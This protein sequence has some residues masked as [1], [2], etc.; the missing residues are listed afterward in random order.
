MPKT[1][2]RVA[3]E[4][5]QRNQATMEH[6]TKVLDAEAARVLALGQ[7]MGQQELGGFYRSVIPGL[8]DRWGRVNATAAMQYY[9]AQRLEWMRRNPSGL[10]RSSRQATARAADRFAERQL[11]TLLYKASMPEF[12]AV[13]IAEPIIG[14][15]MD[16]MMKAGFGES[17]QA[18]RNALTRAVASYNR[19]TILYN[20]ALDPAVVRVQ[21]I[22]EPT[23]CG[24]CVQMALFSVDHMA[25]SAA[26]Q[27]RSN[28]SSVNYAVHF[29]N[30]CHCSIETIYQGD[31]FI[32]P[33]YYDQFEQ[34]RKD[35]KTSANS[36]PQIVADAMRKSRSQGDLPA[37][38]SKL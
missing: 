27:G 31:D 15:G 32:R 28:I 14:H 1:A 35:S 2:D 16:W 11:Q 21:R 36:T 26:G 17:E 7:G 34:A 33:D 8:I 5:I 6:V 25:P 12:D 20:S 13:K 19:D 30:H 24:F 23:A 4:A 37:D 38:L 29:H 10:S 9:D 22:A 18:I 3:Y